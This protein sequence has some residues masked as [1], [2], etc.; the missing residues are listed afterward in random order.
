[1]KI[2]D[3]NIP[4]LKI[5]E[6][7][8]FCDKRGTFQKIYNENI[9][10]TFNLDIKESYYTISNKNVIRGMH[11]QIPPYE[12]SKIVYVPY[13]KIEDVILDIRKGSPSFGK[14]F[15]IELSDKNNKFLLIPTGL[16]H[17][18]KSLADN[19]NVTYLQTSVYSSDHD[20]GIYYDSFDYY[21]DLDTPII[22][23]RDLDLDNFDNFDTPF[24][25]KENK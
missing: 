17:G 11:F 4:G 5:I 20:M 15:N 18:F 8:A 22:S 24:V 2:T 25:Y 7:I 13:G 6:S 12:H 23:N 9:F 21:W 10:K 3:T 19:T 14:T 16:A 1:M